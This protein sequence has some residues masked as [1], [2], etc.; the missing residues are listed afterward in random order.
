M[1]A[2]NPTIEENLI[3]TNAVACPKEKTLVELPQWALESARESVVL[4]PHPRCSRWGSLNIKLFP[5]NANFAQIS[6]RVKIPEKKYLV[7][8]ISDTG[9]TSNKIDSI[10]IT[11]WIDKE[12]RVLR[13]D[14]HKLV[15]GTPGK[16]WTTRAID[17]ERPEAASEIILT[18]KFF[19]TKD[20]EHVTELSHYIDDI[21]LCAE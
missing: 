14:N 12:N 4:A 13:V 3:L 8:S 15:L 6:S 9:E 16:K 19:A 7:L 17:Y 20:Q 11:K 10:I 18:F 21:R 2:D 5:E 1:P